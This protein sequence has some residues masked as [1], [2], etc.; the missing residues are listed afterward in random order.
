M[1]A[2]QGNPYASYELAKMF[3]DG[4]GTEKDS[5][6]AEKSFKDAFIGF[7]SLEKK[8]HDDKLQYRLGWMLHTGTG[9]EKDDALAEEYW[10]QAARL[11]NVH[12]Q[13]ALGKQWLENG[14]GNPEQALKWLM[15]AAEAENCAAQYALAKLYRDGHYVPQ[16]MERAVELFS[17][18][19]ERGNEYAAYQLGRLYLANEEIPKD[20][21]LAVKWL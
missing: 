12:A 13:Y 14:T 16:D 20:V 19:A 8:S 11:G 10:K 5:E 9:A 18:S 2:K 4:V 15:K 3:R 1:S 6:R 17:Q 21:Q 7:S